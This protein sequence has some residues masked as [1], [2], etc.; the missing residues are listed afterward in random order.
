MSNRNLIP[1]AFSL[2]LPTLAACNADAVG[3]T[4]ST[5]EESGTESSESDSET[6]SDDSESDSESETGGNSQVGDMVDIPAGDFQMGCDE[7]SVADCMSD[8]LPIHLV[9]LS[10]FQIDRTEVTVAAYRECVD[11]GAC[12]EP[13]MD[14][15][16]T[17]PDVPECN[18]DEPGRE[19]HPVNCLIR[20]QALEYCAFRDRRLPT[21]A[22]WEYA[23]RG[24]TERLFPWG[25]ASPSCDLANTS[26]PSPCEDPARTLPVG[27]KPDGVSAFGVHD[28]GGNVREMLSDWYQSEY[29]AMSP[30]ADPQGPTSGEPDPLF[31]EYP[32][33]VTRGGHFMEEEEAWLRAS[34]R[35][36]FLEETSGFT[37]GF[38]CAKSNP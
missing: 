11:S 17:G 18:W 14:N 23:A 13:D 19:Q 6:E 27:S 24:Q 22:E 21:E 8:E 32:Q 37:L 28:M 38:R 4:T 20:P 26:V 35:V 1:I 3:A 16:E 5:S 30:Q 2:V 29:Y 10:A 7:M 31:V 36:P 15:P 33:V 12:T 25:D 34:D 9:S